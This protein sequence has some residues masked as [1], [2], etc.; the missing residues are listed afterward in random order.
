MMAGN[1]MLSMHV[2]EMP[3]RM[4]KKAHRHSSDA[5]ILI[6]SGNGFSLTWR[7]GAFNKHQRVDWQAGTLFVPPIYWYHQHLNP[8]NTPVRYLAINAPWLVEKL[9][10]RFTDQ[11]HDHLPEIE[12][13]W[14]KALESSPGIS[15]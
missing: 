12:N 11:L 13:E 2:S 6:L 4:F 1:T 3:P 9:G 8:G 15:D 7:E 14:Q 5:F 10:L